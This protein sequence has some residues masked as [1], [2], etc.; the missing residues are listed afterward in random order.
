[1]TWLNIQL[2][3]FSMKHIFWSFRLHELLFANLHQ[4]SRHVH[5]AETHRLWT[6]TTWVKS[7]FDE[8]H[9]EKAWGWMLGNLIG[10]W[11]DGWWIMRVGGE[12]DKASNRAGLI[13]CET[14]PCLAIKLSWRPSSESV[15]DD[16]LSSWRR[17]CEWPN[18][19]SFYVE[20]E[21]HKQEQSKVSLVSWCLESVRASNL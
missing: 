2:Y 12:V 3:D 7:I 8:A 11:D 13:K 18:S 17:R 6:D 10:I 15:S 19:K 14:H 16:S 5:Q 20:L 9:S 1:M 4:R 21:P